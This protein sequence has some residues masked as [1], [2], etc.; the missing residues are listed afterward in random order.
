MFRITKGLNLPISGQPEP[1]I[2]SAPV[3]SRVG[4]VAT[5]YIGMKPTMLVQEGDQVRLGQ[6]LFTDK[7]TAGVTF[8]APAAGRVAEINR[9]ERR[10][11]QSLVIEVEGNDAVEFTPLVE[12]D[13][14]RGNREQITELLA[15][16][17][18][19]TSFRT[20]PFSKV[21]AVGTVPRSVFV[22]AMDTNPLAADPM[23]W[24]QSH[25]AD[26]RIGL[27][28]LAKLTDGKVYVCHRP[29][30]VMP[31]VGVPSVLTAAFE[32]PHPAGLPGTHIH[33]LD[34]VGLRKTV[35]YINYQDVIAVGHLVATG[36]IETERMIS[37]AG[38]SVARPQIVRTRLGACVNQLTN[39]MLADG[40]H[41]V[42]SGNVLSGRRIESSICY[43]G[44]YHLQVSAIPEN[45]HREF[46]GWMSPGADRFSVKNI[47]TSALN[48]ARTF[49]FTTTTGGS[50]RAMVPIGMYEKVMP[51]DVLP[52][53]LLRSLITKDTEQ[54]QALG[55][56]ELDEEDLALCT[57]VCPGKTEYGPL[58][59][60]SL[61]QIELDG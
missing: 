9:G 50:K 45:S 42:I 25:E 52:T 21:P 29:D 49:A 28:S 54:A 30:S 13:F 44:R 6:P 34:P 37:I 48:R 36:R 2:V 60:A 59:R 19:W 27:Q 8:T 4:L 47:F 55:C 11:L 17:G 5:D 12:K 7:K 23:P 58:L 14:L 41:R 10:M 22:Q 20:R 26:F 46:L 24:I 57:F 31:N 38:P 51:L 40:T 39:G 56:M 61:N 43:L 33:F 53:F 35:W 32:G 3:V 16:S 18:L 15:S 1:Q